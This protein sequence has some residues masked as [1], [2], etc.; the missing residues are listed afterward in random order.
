MWTPSSKWLIVLCFVAASGVTFAAWWIRG[1]PRSG[2]VAVPVFAG[3]GALF[4]L[5]ERIRSRR[6]DRRDERF[7]KFDIQATAVAGLAVMGA[8][9]VA[10]LVEVA[11]GHNAWQY[12]WL[13]IVGVWA[14]LGALYVQRLRG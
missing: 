4:L 6:G 12:D 14:Y 3:C 13:L 10:T 9:V 11:R 1:D 8:V 2:L 5:G 7:R